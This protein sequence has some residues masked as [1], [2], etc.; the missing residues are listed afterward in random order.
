[1]HISSTL[2][3]T[4]GELRFLTNIPSSF[5][6]NTEYASEIVIESG[7]PSGTATIIIVRERV[8]ASTILLK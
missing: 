5:I 2:P 7:S 4:S 8:I 6:L 1:M 3:I